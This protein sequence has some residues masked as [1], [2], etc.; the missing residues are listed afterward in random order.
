MGNL[1]LLE[2]HDWAATSL[3]PRAGWPPEM[4]A[5][6]ATAMASGF[7]TCLGLGPELLQVYNDA[8]NPIFGTK[9]PQS[10]CRPALETWP[11]ITCSGEMLV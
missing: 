8:Y 2:R 3:G 9:H 4:Q 5:A 11:E 1:D 10:F 7:P 6:V